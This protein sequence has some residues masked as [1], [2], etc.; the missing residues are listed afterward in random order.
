MKHILPVTDCTDIAAAELHGTL[1]TNLDELGSDRDVAVSPAAEVK[2]F[3]VKNWNFVARLLAESYNPVNLTILAVVNAVDSSL[4][5]RARI[6]VKLKNWLQLVWANTGVFSSLIEDF[7][8]DEI[9]ETNPTW[10]KGTD[11]V[12]F[13]WKYI[14]AP[15][16]AKF[17]TTWNIEDIREKDFSLD[18]LVKLKYELGEIVHI[19]NFWNMKIAYH[20]DNFKASEGDVFEI[21]LN[22]KPITR[23]IYSKSMKELEEWVVT[24]YKWSSMW[25]MELACVRQLNYSDIIWAEIGDVITINRK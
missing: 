17:A 8:I 1:V 6:A 12:S 14:H 24:I 21:S 9:V 22:G 23:A 18:R 3:S 13:G 25:L 7:G 15:I 20:D 16:A 10:L 19:D 4:D 11:F 2:E 5:S